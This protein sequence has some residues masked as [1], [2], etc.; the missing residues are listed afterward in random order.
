R[1]GHSDQGRA[2]MVIPEVE[3]MS[4]FEHHVAPTPAHGAGDGLPE[5]LPRA[6]GTSPARRSDKW[7]GILLTAVSAMAASGAQAFWAD[8]LSP[9]DLDGDGGVDAWSDSRS[10]STWLA[11]W[12]SRELVT[13]Q[14]AFDWAEGLSFRGATDWQLPRN[15]SVTPDP[16]CS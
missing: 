12:T 1:T 16:Q 9:R 13:W 4:E 14:E 6:E 10:D 5:P 15:P 11:D 7:C 8:H 2:G 3:R